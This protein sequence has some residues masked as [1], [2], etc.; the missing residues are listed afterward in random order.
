MDF[1]SDE[2]ML[3]LFYIKIN[4]FGLFVI[5]NPFQVEK[6]VHLKYHFIFYAVSGEK[7][8]KK[9][10]PAQFSVKLVSMLNPIIDSILNAED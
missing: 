3:C 1:E 9:T 7:K 2:E 5:T 10:P 6:R 4:K 8:K